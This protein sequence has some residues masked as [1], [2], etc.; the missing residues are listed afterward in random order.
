[1]AQIYSLAPPTTLSS[2]FVSLKLDRRQSTTYVIPARHPKTSRL[3]LHYVLVFL[4]YHVL[5]LLLTTVNDQFQLYKAV[6]LLI[7][8][9]DDK[10]P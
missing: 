7:Q 10:V 1:M 8:G 3:L 2:L 5:L 4:R 6:F 9:Q